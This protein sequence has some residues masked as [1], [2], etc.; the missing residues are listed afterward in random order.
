[1]LASIRC[2]AVTAAA[3][4]FTLPLG[5]QDGSAPVWDG[6]LEQKSTGGYYSLNWAAPSG[7]FASFYVEEAP[8]P[9]FVQGERRQVYDGKDS[10]TTISGKADGTY[11]YRVHV[12]RGDGT[13]TP[14]S[15]TLS[16]TVEH[17]SLERAFSFLITGALVFLAT[18]AMILSGW[19]RERRK[20]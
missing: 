16:V 20:S 9:D 6:D 13:R 1:M 5:A 12:E 8:T 7:D 19:M 17:H 4:L 14:W 15:E 18:A 2:F 11:Y 10:G 3:L